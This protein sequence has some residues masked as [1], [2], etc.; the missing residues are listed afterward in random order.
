M[1]MTNP[2]PQRNRF[3]RYGMAAAIAFLALLIVTAVVLHEPQAEP[4]GGAMEASQ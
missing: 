3:V 4:L 2:H 1:Q